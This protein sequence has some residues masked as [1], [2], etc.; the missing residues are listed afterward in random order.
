[1]FENSSWK[2]LEKSALFNYTSF[3]LKIINIPFKYLNFRPK[4]GKLIVDSGIL[5]LCMKIF[6]NEYS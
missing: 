6:N 2:I 4:F 5:E 3:L 1:M